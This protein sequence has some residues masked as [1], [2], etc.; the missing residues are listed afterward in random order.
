MHG[1]EKSKPHNGNNQMS[2][3]AIVT[4]ANRGIGSALA[5][6]LAASGMHVVA[7][8]RHAGGLP[9]LKNVTNVE[10]DVSSEESIR[11]FVQ[12]MNGMDAVGKV[13]LLFNSAGM[14]KPEKSLM[15]CNE[16]D[17]IQHFKVN[18]IGPLLMAKYL[19]EGKFLTDTKG[20]KQFTGGPKV[21][22]IIANMSAKSG[23]IGEN[24]LGG[25]YS[26]RASKA[27]LNQVTRTLAA[28]LGRKGIVTVSLHPGTVRTDMSAFFINNLKG[29]VI[30]TPEEAAQHLLVVLS[31]L[32][33]SDNGKFLD[34]DMKTIPW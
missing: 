16:T 33:E 1:H 9:D 5:K 22:S 6:S 28:E 11:G 13:R 31:K 14:L 15:Q 29:H 3:I 7:T 4:G 34:Y 10:L 21:P 26:Y 2:G 23:S 20:A 18:T 17:L 12:K 27:A 32:T 30:F 8:A 19:V 24:A 25:W